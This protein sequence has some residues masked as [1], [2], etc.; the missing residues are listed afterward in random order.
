MRC[1]GLAH[2]RL[3]AHRAIS[4]GPRQQESILHV[5]HALEGGTRR[6]GPG[7]TRAAGRPQVSE[8]ATWSSRYYGRIISAALAAVG[9]RRAA[10]GPCTGTAAQVPSASACGQRPA[11]HRAPAALHLLVLVNLGC[12]G[13]TAGVTQLDICWPDLAHRLFI[14]RCGVRSAVHAGPAPGPAGHRPGHAAAQPRQRG[15][16]QPRAQHADPGRAAE[17]RQLPKVHT[18]GAPATSPSRIP[19]VLPAEFTAAVAGGQFAAHRSRCPYQ[20]PAGKGLLGKHASVPPAHAD[21]PGSAS[22]PS[23]APPCAGPPAARAQ[24]GRAG[25]RRGGRA[26]GRRPARPG[27]GGGGGRG[28][29]VLHRHL[30]LR[31]RWRPPLPPGARACQAGQNQHCPD[32]TARMVCLE[33]RCQPM[34]CSAAWVCTQAA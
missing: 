13:V 33:G 24:A 12:A 1:R 30:L 5:L 16:A 17:L 26:G 20:R 34:F 25:V 15:R 6:G 3:W 31:G 10:A 14:T 29:H 4:E 22:H 32:W 23:P 11:A 27:A 9:A 18:G 21:F 28:R 7:L 19:K 2:A 8:H